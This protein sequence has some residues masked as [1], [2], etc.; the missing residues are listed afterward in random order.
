MRT[1]PPYAHAANLSAETTR[2]RSTEILAVQ[3]VSRLRTFGGVESGEIQTVLLLQTGAAFEERTELSARTA[4][5]TNLTRSKARANFG[6]M[7][8]D[9]KLQAVEEGPSNAQ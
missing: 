6:I 3:R 9:S 7:G 5:A 4:A 1:K 8:S 2:A